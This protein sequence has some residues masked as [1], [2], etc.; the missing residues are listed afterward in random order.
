MCKLDFFSISTEPG[1]YFNYEIVSKQTNLSK[2]ESNLFRSGL[3]KMG[4]INFNFIF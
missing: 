1:F 3:K 2:V 4:V